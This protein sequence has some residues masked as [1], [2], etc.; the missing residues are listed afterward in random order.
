MTNDSHG[1]FVSSD[2]LSNERMNFQLL[3]RRRGIVDHAVLKAMDEVPREEFVEPMSARRGLCGRGAADRLRPDHQPAV[4]RRLHD[5]AAAAS[6]A[7]PRARD[8][9]RLGLPG[10]GAVA[11]CRRGGHGRALPHAGRQR[12]PAAAPSRPRQCRGADRGRICSCPS[13]SACSTASWSRRRWRRCRE[14][15]Q[16]R[17]SVTASCLHRSARTTASRC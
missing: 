14:A 17:L 5:R 1:P 7:P 4:R 9:H 13:I 2:D 16:D 10:G 3:L 12:A 8:R 6:A 15:L 11:S